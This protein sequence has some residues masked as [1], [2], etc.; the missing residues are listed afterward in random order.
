MLATIGGFVFHKIHGN[1]LLLMTAL[2]II[3]NSV[4]FATMPDNPN[5]WRWVFPAM[6][7][8]TLA[9]DIVF[10]AASIF[11]TTTMPSKQQGFAGALTNVLFQ[12]GIAV[13]LGFADVVASNTRYQGERQSYKNAFW[14]EM[15]CGAAALVIFM[16]FVRIRA[17]TSDKT[18]DEK[19]EEKALEQQRV[20]RR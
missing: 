15:A 20:E 9:V 18:A 13:L 16:G 10:T 4:L 12:L 2:A 8:A 1:I 3:V 14:F 6:C 5:Y 11:F 7:C 19:A 17:A